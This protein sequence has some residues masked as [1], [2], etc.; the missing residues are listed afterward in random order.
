MTDQSLLAELSSIQPNESTEPERSFQPPGAGG[1]M[2]PGGAGLPGGPAGPGGPGFPAGPTGPGGLGFPGGPGFSGGP[3]G[4]GGP[5]FPGGGPGFPGGSTGSAG[6]GFPGGG[7]GFPGGPMGPGGLGFPGGPG[8]PCGP[9]GPGGPGFPGGPIGPGGVPPQLAPGNLTAILAQHPRPVGQPSGEMVLLYNILRN[10]PAML[11]LVIQQRPQSL[12]QA[13]Q[14]AQFGGT[15]APRYSDS[16]ILPGFCF[17]RWTIAFTFNN[18]YLFYPVTNQFG[19][20]IA[21]CYPFLSPCIVPNF[22]ILF[23]LC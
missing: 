11:Q 14:F 7:P 18:V 12:Q 3:M 13:I 21:Y 1:P 16:R 17:N 23:A 6:S 15:G 22:S 8:F 5:G 9:T 20:V 19:F 4:P 2:G 10:N